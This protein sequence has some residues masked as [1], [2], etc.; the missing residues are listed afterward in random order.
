[1][2][3][4]PP[5]ATVTILFA[6]TVLINGALWGQCDSIYTAFLIAFLYFLLSGRTTLAF[7]AYGLAF[8]FKLQAIFLAPF[9]LWIIAAKR[10]RYAYVF[11]CPIVYF[12][13][14]LPAWTLG[15]PIDELLLIYYN[16]SQSYSGHLT[17]NMA[18]IYNWLPNYPDIFLPIGIG[19][20]G[21]LVVI[22]AFL[23]H[24][25]NVRL[26]NEMLVFF[27]AF[28]VILIPYILP[29][30]HERYWFPADIMSIVLAFYIPK[31][32]WIP[33]SL[34]LI[35]VVPYF[36]YLFGIQAMPLHWL[37]IAPLLVLIF[38]VQHLGSLLKRRTSAATGGLSPPHC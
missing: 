16:Q 19:F 13:S 30:M 6:P 18:N 35:S 21:C 5:L 37:A 3:P 22:I 32:F 2:Y 26:S 34:Q 23:L 11:I 9:I 8:S 7:C 17:L 15:K 1:M 27:A 12:L 31:Y 10:I 14:I 29:K 24:R 25:S 33:V 36:S 20:T 38:L 28:S 4:F